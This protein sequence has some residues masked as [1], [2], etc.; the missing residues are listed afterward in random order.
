MEQNNTWIHM[1]VPTAM[2]VSMVLKPAQILTVILEVVR[3]R[4]DQQVNPILGDR[5]NMETKYSSSTNMGQNHTWTHV[6]V[7]PVVDT[8]QG[9][10]IKLGIKPHM[11]LLL[12]ICIFL[13][14][15]VII[16]PKTFTEN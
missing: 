9:F 11:H 15:H 13:L 3:G 10:L 5:L 2:V 16:R 8:A 6:A 1:V 14:Y 12:E 7:L 4:S